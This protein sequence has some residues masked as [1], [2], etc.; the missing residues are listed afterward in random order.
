M[1]LDDVLQLFLDRLK[2]ARLDEGALG[3]VGKECR[4]LFKGG[5][6]FRGLRHAKASHDGQRMDASSSF[7]LQKHSVGLRREIEVMLLSNDRASHEF[8][9]PSGMP[10]LREPRGKMPP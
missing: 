5:V 8:F 6:A 7:S 10:G 9:T 3:Q 2:I 1:A 4:L